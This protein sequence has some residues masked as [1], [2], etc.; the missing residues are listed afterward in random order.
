[1][2]FRDPF[3]PPRQLLMVFFL[4]ALASTAVVGWLTWQLVVLDQAAERQRQ[5]DS[6]ERAADAAVAV[7]QRELSTLERLL[8]RGA[9]SDVHPPDGIMTIYVDDGMVQVAP[10]GVLLY[11]PA[12]RRKAPVSHQ[13]LDAAGRLEFV[14]RDLQGAARL[15]WSVAGGANPLVAAWALARLGGIHRQ[16]GAHTAALAVYDRLVT[17]GP[18]DVEGIPAG[19]V[20]RVGRMETFEAAGQP[21]EARVEAARLQSELRA[22]RYPVTAAQYRQYSAEA[23]RRSDDSRPDDSNAIARAEAAR[24]IWENRTEAAQGWRVLSR[25]EGGV[26]VG[27]RGEGTRLSAVVLDPAHLAR[28]VTAA[29]PAPYRWSLS[30][31]AGE[32]LGGDAPPRR[33]VAL[34]SAAATALPWTLHVFPD[35]ARPAAPASAREHLLRLVLG[36]V[37]CL[38]VTGWYFIW[39]GVSREVRAARLQ[40]DFVA[41][42]SHE[43]RSPL[44]A[45]RHIADL[46]TS[47]RMPTEERRRRAYALL[48]SETDRLSRLVEG[49]LEF[50]Q[51]QAGHVTIERAPL[52]AAAIVSRTVVDFRRGLDASRAHVVELEDRAGGA[53]VLG[54]ADALGRV[55]WN[56]LDN[57]IKYSPGAAHVRVRLDRRDDGAVAMSVQ[58]SGR[59]ISADER[60]RIFDRFVRG[61]DA[62]AERIRGTGIGLAIVRE[63]VRAHGGRIDVDSEPGRGSTFTVVLPPP[64]SAAADGA[65]APLPTSTVNTEIAAEERG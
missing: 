6:L 13:T 26:L 43:F 12:W 20:A 14:D 1:M 15:Y 39:R 11:E 8:A 29:V 10:A 48:E 41:A 35:P 19:I 40:S 4:V 31:L 33:Q 53:M 22:G 34:R 45:L 2:R 9:G 58:D 46:L 3:T 5:L 38:L 37:G 57:A 27:W 25:A 32:L 47:D 55:I 51:I 62:K 21:A 59:G 50:A 42:V 44:T 7:L 52:Q 28:L 16:T 18:A 30:D 23:A 56:L 54:D 36:G 64:P 63:I 24:W 61:R 17:L 60:G 49:L 65:P